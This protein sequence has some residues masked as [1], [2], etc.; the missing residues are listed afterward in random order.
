MADVEVEK[1]NK[2]LEKLCTDCS[3]DVRK[4]LVS[5]SKAVVARMI[6]MADDMEKVKVPS[7][8]P[9]A[10]D[11]VPDRLNAVLKR[12]SA[13]FAGV[14]VFTAR[15]EINTGKLSVEGPGISGPLA[16]FY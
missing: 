4:L 14:L 7:T 16:G 12:E 8:S 6:K 11:N 1:L 3:A 5:C 10:L 13:R 15:V 2:A 9:D